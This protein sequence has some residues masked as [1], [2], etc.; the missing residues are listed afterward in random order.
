VQV[1]ALHPDFDIRNPNRVRALVGAFSAGNPAQFHAASG[2]GYRFLAEMV[3]ALDPVNA[4]VAARVVSPLTDWKRQAEPRAAIMRAEL[5]RILARPG[6]SKGTF[7][8]VSKGLAV[9]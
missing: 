7:E 1:L 9:H 5:E 2:E 4:Q 8:K 3:I 6:L